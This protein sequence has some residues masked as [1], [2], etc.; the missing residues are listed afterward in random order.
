MF[1]Q[2]PFRLHGG[3]NHDPR[4][5]VMT[6]LNSHA[7]GLCN[8]WVAWSQ[9]RQYQRTLRDGTR[10]LVFAFPVP[11][12]DGHVPTRRPLWPLGRM[13]PSRSQIPKPEMTKGSA[14][15][16]GLRDGSTYGVDP[17]WLPLWSMGLHAFKP[18]AELSGAGVR[19]AQGMTLPGILPWCRAR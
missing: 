16:P 7:P 1:I 18:I 17:T 11:A 13:A 5:V 14:L 3:K 4:K 12:R 2:I 6:S 10:V 8:P 9:A 15:G 19:R